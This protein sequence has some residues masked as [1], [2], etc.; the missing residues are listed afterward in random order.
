MLCGSTEDKC[1]ASE[2]RRRK[3]KGCVRCLQ[4]GQN[5]PFAFLFLL[6][7]VVAWF[8]GVGVVVIMV[9]VAAA[10]A[11]AGTASPSVS[12]GTGTAAAGSAVVAMTSAAGAGAS[13]SAT[14][15]ATSFSGC[16]IVPPAPNSTML[17]AHSLQA[18]RWR[19]GRRTT[20]RGED[21]QRRHS[22]EG[23]SSVMWCVAVVAVFIG[24]YVWASLEV[25]A[26]VVGATGCVAVDERP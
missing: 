5:Q 21:R 26:G 8:V 4:T 7:V 17:R 1:T 6:V 14:G 3:K 23:S 16:T 12:T 13:T 20:S 11:G 22:E 24:G 19:H 9:S 10:G 18:T 2:E 15:A 25:G